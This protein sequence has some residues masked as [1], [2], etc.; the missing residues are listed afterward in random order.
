[1]NDEVLLVSGWI[2]V[3]VVVMNE[4]V[5]SIAAV[6]VEICVDVVEKLIEVVVVAGI[7]DCFGKLSA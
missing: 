6:F 3:V 7:L 5:V 2:G 4:G 1:M